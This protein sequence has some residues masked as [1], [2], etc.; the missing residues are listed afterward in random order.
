LQREIRGHYKPFLQGNLN[1]SDIPFIY[2]FLSGAGTGKSRNANEF[3]QMA[4]SCLLSSKD[5]ELL[6]GI[7]DV[8]MFHISFDNGTPLQPGKILFWC[9]YSNR[10]EMRFDEVVHT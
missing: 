9:W 2:L 1:K 10:K 4:I 8:H 6:A 5:K 7:K 3:Y